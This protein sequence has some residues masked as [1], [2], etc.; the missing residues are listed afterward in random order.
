[1]NNELYYIY[2]NL[3]RKTA[4]KVSNKFHIEYEECFSEACL[5]LVKSFYSFNPNK[6]CFSTHLYH[7]LKELYGFAKKNFPCNRLPE[8]YD[9]PYIQR[10]LSPIDEY[11][12]TGLE[13]EIV[14]HTKENYYNNQKFSHKKITIKDIKKHFKEKEIPEYQIKNAIKNIQWGIKNV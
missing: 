1:M 10:F 5:I 7:N 2:E 4:Y 11:G 14:E 12:F 9:I 13:K 3:L 6:A 8:N